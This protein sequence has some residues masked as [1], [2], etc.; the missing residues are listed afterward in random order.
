MISVALHSH[1]VKL[2]R[3]LAPALGR[4]FEVVVEPNET[5]VKRLLEKG[6]CDILIL[7]LDSGYGTVDQQV[8]LFDDI[9]ASRIA[10]V[11]MTDDDSRPAAIDL[12]Q[13]GAY[14]YFRKPPALRELKTSLQRAYE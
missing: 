13:R 12:V 7:D 8:R 5:G 2:Q 6:A 11:A 3:L 10:V 14:S 1:D 4:E 9:A